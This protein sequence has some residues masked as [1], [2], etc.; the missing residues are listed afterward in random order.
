MMADHVMSWLFALF[1]VINMVLG[2]AQP[3]SQKPL[4]T[5]LS[6]NY[7]L[8]LLYEAVDSNIE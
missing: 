4:Q 2:F 8:R 5:P 7:G 3:D 6:S 1:S